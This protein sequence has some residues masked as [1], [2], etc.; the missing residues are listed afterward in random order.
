MPWLPFCQLPEQDLKAILAF[1][2]TQ[3]PVYNA[4]ETHPAQLQ[5]VKPVS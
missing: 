3:L 1:L 5:P 4:V 2:K